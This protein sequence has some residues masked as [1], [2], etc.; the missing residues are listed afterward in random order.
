MQ[1]APKQ[2]H[3][4]LKSKDSSTSNK[5]LSPNLWAAPILSTWVEEQERERI[6]WRIEKKNKQN[7]KGKTILDLDILIKYF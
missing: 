3:W 4:S 6:Q 7:I 1:G 2:R 5:R